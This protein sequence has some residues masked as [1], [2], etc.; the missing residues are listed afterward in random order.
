MTEQMKAVALNQYGGPE[1]LETM[2][3]DVPRFAM[4][5]EVLIDVHAAGVNPFDKKIRSGLFKQIF[6]RSFPL[7]PGCDF[8]GTIAAKGFDVSEFEVGDKVWGMIDPIR[9]GTYAEK[10]ASSSYAVRKMPENL[11][12]EEAASVPMGTVTA[13]FALKNLASVQSGQRVLVNGGAGGVGSA[14]I[15]IAKHLGAW[16]AATC[17]TKNVDFCRNLGADEVVDYTKE[18]IRDKLSGIDVT[19]DPIGGETN[20]RSYEVMKRGGT[21]LVILRMDPIEMEGSPAL[22]KEYG[23]IRKEVVFSAQPEILDTLKPLYESGALKP[24]VTGVFPLE[25][26]KKAH[27]QI[28]TGHTRGKLVLRVRS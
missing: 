12:F 20:L 28:D 18:D 14:A 25:E 2:E 5:N 16:V 10:T 22:A 7:V 6:P 24:T 26:A 27:E 1:V 21:M 8:A 19:L 15:Q 9:S 13:W 4:H 17:S 3:V 23:I 11:S